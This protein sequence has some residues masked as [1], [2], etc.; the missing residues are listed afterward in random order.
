MGLGEI[1]CSKDVSLTQQSGADECDIN[2]IVERAKRGADISGL[3]RPNPPLYG[4]LIGAPDYREALQAVVDAKAAFES[5]DARIRE[6]FGND[7]VRMLEFLDDPANRDEAIKLGLVK[8]PPEPVSSGDP[9]L[10]KGVSPAAVRE[11]HGS[12]VK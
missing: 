8:A 4:S 2:C 5:L 10:A 11:S 9:E 7:A 1:D 3:I 12:G 6:R